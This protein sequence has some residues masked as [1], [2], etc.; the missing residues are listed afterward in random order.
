MKKAPAYTLTNSSIVVIVDGKTHAV[1]AGSPQYTALKKAILSEDWDAIPNN[2]S[3][4]K[5]L[6]SWLNNPNWCITDAGLT[7]KGNHVPASI[8]SR[9]NAMAT[10]GESP[11]PLLKFYERLALNPSNRSVTQLYDFLQHTGIPLTEDGYI[12]CYKAV[13]HD[14]KDY[15]SGKLTNSIG[16]VMQMPR[17]QISD[18]PREACHEG[19]H[20]GALTYASAFGSEDR[21]IIICKVDPADVVS[22]PYDKSFKKV[23]VCKYEVIGHHNGEELSSTTHLDEAKEDRN[24]AC[25]CLESDHE[26]DGN[27][28]C[29]TCPCTG[30]VAAHDCDGGNCEECDDEEGVEYEDEDKVINEASQSKPARTGRNHKF[31]KM[32]LT[33]LMNQSTEELRQYASKRLKIIGASKIVGGKLALVNRILAVK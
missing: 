18:D 29:G 12:L 13:Q 28:A 27:D 16:A 11:Q 10:N 26:G 9:C 15:H 30:F 21:R 24:C 3:V 25:G 20:V 4:G 5:S 22:V 19:L 7:Y 32:D 33:E 1:Q 6:A 17:N 31:D 14:Y 2:L 23:R 8:N